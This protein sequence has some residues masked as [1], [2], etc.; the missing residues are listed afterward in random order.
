MVADKNGFYY[1]KIDTVKC[2]ECHKCEKTCPN[3]Q[4]F[5][6]NVSEFYMGWHKDKAVLLNSS[7]G[8]AFTAIAQYI[9]RK[10]GIVFGA[11]F[12]EATRSVKH[13]SIEQERQLGKLRLSKYFQG[14]INDCYKD[15]E[16]ELTKKEFDLLAYLLANRNKVISREQALDV[17]WGYDFVGNTNVVDVYVRYLR[18]KIDDVFGITVIETVRGCGYVIR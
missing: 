12:D 15:T 2:I 9:L 1:P 13:I 18:T 8:G 17:V 4:D 7:S 3:N 10:G 16:I 6:R 11:Y 14:R 5:N